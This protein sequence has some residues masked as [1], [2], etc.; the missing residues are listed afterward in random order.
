MSGIVLQSQIVKEPIGI[1]TVAH[2]ILDSYGSIIHAV[3]LLSLRHPPVKMDLSSVPYKI[4][5]SEVVE[6]FR[7]PWVPSNKTAQLSATAFLDTFGPQTPTAASFRQGIV[8]MSR[9]LLGS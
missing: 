5:A 2:A 3:Q 8:R 4:V 6:I 7:I 1:G 9:I